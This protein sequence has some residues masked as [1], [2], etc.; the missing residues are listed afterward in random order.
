MITADIE[1]RVQGLTDRAGF[2]GTFA[3]QPDYELQPGDC[4]IEWDGGGADR[5]EAR[6]WQEIRA[7]IATTLG[8]IDTEKLEAASQMLAEKAEADAPED[9]APPA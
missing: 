2:R 3:V 5:D 4:R 1:A 6:I 9:A 8:D 7:A